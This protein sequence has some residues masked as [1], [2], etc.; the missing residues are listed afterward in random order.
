MLDKGEGIW[1]AIGLA[2]NFNLVYLTLS[3]N[4]FMCVIFN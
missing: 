2:Y 4:I 1:N 3:A